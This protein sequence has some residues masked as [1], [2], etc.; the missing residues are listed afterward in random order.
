MSNFTHVDL[1]GLDETRMHDAPAVVSQE[2][3]RGLLL[4]TPAHRQLSI[5]GMRHSQGGHTAVADGR[6]LLTE[7]FGRIDLPAGG[8]PATPHLPTVV[9]VDAGAVWSAIHRRVS[10]A[11]KAPRVQQSSAHFSV[12][13]SLA[14][15]CH[16]R[17]VRWGSV[18]QTVES[19]TLLAGSGHTINASRT[20]RPEVFRAVLGGYGAGGLILRAR[21]MLTPNDMLQRYTEVCDLGRYQEIVERI[22]S[23]SFNTIETPSRGVLQLQHGWL[24]CSKS[25]Y[26]QQVLSYTV[27]RG[28]PTAGTEHG[29]PIHPGQLRAEAWG[30]SELLRAGWVAARRNGDF[31]SLVWEQLRKETAAA[32]GP[33][34]RLDYLRE[35]IMFT[36]SQADAEG[37]DLL[38]EYFVPVK[39]LP[40]FLNRLRSEIFPYDPNGKGTGLSVLSC[41]LR[42]VAADS[43]DDGP[44]LSYCAGESRVSVAIDAHVRRKDGDLHPDAVQR[45]GRAIDSALEHKGT[46]Y[47]PYRRFASAEQLHAGYPGLND[48]QKVVKSLDP[49]RRFHNAFLAHYGL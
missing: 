5:A 9:D 48:W 32:T 43:Q 21:L 46:F 16:G 12:G 49:D 35:E 18:S 34:S 47:L 17:E 42:H 33:C 15:N 28:P 23:G 20:E 1:T 7:T 22:D 39:A 30:T 36:S 14:V 10:P 41:T 40:S 25:Q 2:H 27:R 37:V 6:M 19:M 8:P 11:G 3:A 44:W 29:V 4:Q 13:G 26:M 31:R 24:N 45:F 38:Q